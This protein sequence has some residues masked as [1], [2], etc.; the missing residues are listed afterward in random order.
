MYFY[1]GGARQP[2]QE[3]IVTSK[4]DALPSG[5][6]AAD[7]LPHAEST[8]TSP[9]VRRN[10]AQPLQRTS[11]PSERILLSG[12][13]LNVKSIQ[14]L[15]QSENFDAWIEKFSNQSASDPNAA[16]LSSIYTRLLHEQVASN[17]VRADFQ[18]IVCG[19]AVCVGSLR[20]GNEAEYQRWSN[21]IFNDPK[22]PNYGFAD[23]TI[24]RSDGSLE[25]RFVFSTDPKANSATI[26]R[27]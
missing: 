25:H 4:S 5:S 12:D 10:T 8:T 23:M 11:L 18:R 3:N 24:K 2:A 20:N 19:T 27:L 15:L 13:A 6:I 1:H 22:T 26:P 9:A 16:E 21:I 7:N 14:S 17:Q